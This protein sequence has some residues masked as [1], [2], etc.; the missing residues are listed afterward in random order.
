M[1][2]SYSTR[3]SAAV[4]DGAL[5]SAAAVASKK[6]TS[7]GLARGGAEGGGKE[8]GGALRVVSLLG[9]ATEIIYLLGGE[10]LLVGRSHECKR[11]AS[12]LSLPC[13]SRPP[14]FLAARQ[15]RAAGTN[16][17]V[18]GEAGGDGDRGYYYS[19]ERLDN[20]SGEAI[21][22]AA[23]E[24]AYI[25]V[26]MDE[27][28]CDGS[29]REMEGAGGAGGDG[30]RAS[31][32]ARMTARKVDRILRERL[33]KGLARYQV[34]AEKL[35]Q[36][37][38]D[39]IITQDQCS[40]CAVTVDDL[41]DAC[42]RYL[43]EQG[44]RCRIV[45]LKPL[46]VAD[47]YSNIQTIADAIG[48]TDE[49]HNVVGWL[50][51]RWNS[52]RH[53]SPQW[54]DGVPQVSVACLQWLDPLIG[55]GFWVPEIVCCA[56]GTN[57][58]GSPGGESPRITFED[59]EK[60][61]P[62]MIVVMCCG[63]S[64]DQTV[65]AMASLE[66]NK[67]W[68]SLRAVQT[69][70]VYIA[71]GDCYFNTSGP[72]V[73]DSA[74]MM[75]EILHGVGLADDNGTKLRRYE[76][77]G[78]IRWVGSAK[79][80]SVVRGS[81]P[82]NQ[83]AP[84]SETAERELQERWMDRDR[85]S[86]DEIT[87][88]GEGGMQR[89]GGGRLHD[90]QDRVQD[91]YTEGGRSFNGVTK[92]GGANTWI[93]DR[94]GGGVRPP[95][96]GGFSAGARVHSGGYVV[97]SDSATVAESDAATNTTGPGTG[98]A[99]PTESDDGSVAIHIEERRYGVEQGRYGVSRGMPAA[100]REVVVSK[101]DWKGK[102]KSGGSKAGGVQ[103]GVGM[104]G[105]ADKG[106]VMVMGGGVD[107]TAGGTNWDLNGGDDVQ[108]KYGD[109]AR[110]DTM[111]KKEG[112]GWMRK[113]G[114]GVRRGSGRVDS[115]VMVVGERPKSRRELEASALNNLW[116][117][118]EAAASRTGGLRGPASSHGGD[119][120]RHSSLRS[121]KDGMNSLRRSRDSSLHTSQQTAGD[122]RALENCRPPSQPEHLPDDERLGAE[123]K[124]LNLK[125]AELRE[126][127][128]DVLAE[129]VPADAILLSG[130]LDTCVLA[131]AGRLAMAARRQKLKEAGSR[132]AISASSECAF[133]MGITVIAGPHATDGPYARE[134][135]K[136]CE[137]LHS[138]VGGEDSSMTPADLLEKEVEFVVRTLGC[139]D[140]MEVRNSIAVA[141]ALKEA[142][143][144][145]VKTVVTGDGADEVF[146]G[147]SFMT[148]MSEDKL[149]EYREHLRKV[150]SFSACPLGQALGIEVRQPYLHPR[151]IEFAKTCT[152]AHLVGE[153]N[154][155]VPAHIDRPK[156][157]IYGKLILRQAFPGVHSAWRRKD[158]IEVPLSSL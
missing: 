59:L 24:S 49:G 54:M 81:K 32:Q 53:N 6:A 68:D 61:D 124:P 20:G 139:F 118:T 48:L 131:E 38:P 149:D 9:A 79:F 85:G 158:P 72:S 33:E 82:A 46:T 135:A 80:A 17:T 142:K 21:E 157:S 121:S 110:W 26:M 143:R 43:R 119:S 136:R 63:W 22:E 114:V 151:V 122:S 11:P 30:L 74:E 94:A 16:T 77:F 7:G 148:S 14:N 113:V 29:A 92:R 96:G 141:A 127:M 5:S 4:A 41:N 101:W 150:M 1:D 51:S 34:D 19:N 129:M 154:M 57:L 134:I 67:G 120:P 78:Y 99:T 123:R 116:S 12:V 126:I 71:D 23:G 65:R 44:G 93:G 152:K 130:G 147:Y 109:T 35:R 18:G 13:V 40:V 88:G 25:N 156:D 100:P 76:G 70:R 103:L 3:L 102:M 66:R 104:F 106:S 69:H 83:K 133:K 39:I 144:L 62:D 42:A 28:R 58:F 52:V 15:A 117:L 107:G 73:V 105:S 138:V 31:A 55:A 87:R 84:L 125:A 153:A 56:G 91:E 98:T 10:N 97:E 50:K 64:I 111:G 8:E 2:S 27:W 60:V 36:L 86:R 155:D 112:V 45:A 115:V 137:L 108:G 146:A 132:E 37:R 47:V 128:V 90:E 145:A 95:E 89:G 75:A 140:P